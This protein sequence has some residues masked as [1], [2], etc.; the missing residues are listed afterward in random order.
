MRNLRFLHRALSFGD[1]QKSNGQHGANDVHVERN[2]RVAGREVACNQHL[3][4]M[5]NGIAEQENGGSTNGRRFEIQVTPKGDHCGRT[6]GQVSHADLELE[7]AHV[8]T[9]QL[10]S[11]SGKEDMKSP[12]PQ[13]CDANGE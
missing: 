12:S 11:R 4:D 2:A 1:Y 7:R 10:R 13:P 5:S 8:P 9:N 6:D 3:L